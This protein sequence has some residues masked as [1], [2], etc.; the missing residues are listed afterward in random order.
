MTELIRYSVD[1]GIAQI[2]LDRPQK[3]N[4]LN[5]EMLAGLQQS[6]D[7][8]ERDATVRV[9]VL[10]GNG[11]RSFC[12]G[13]DI[14]EWSE[15]TALEMWKGWIRPGNQIMNRISQLAIPVIASLNGLALGGGLELALT[16]DIRIAADHALLGAPEVKLGIIPGW[17]GTQR[18][19][20]T[21]GSSRAK[22]MIFTGEQISADTALN[23]GLVN[24]VV[25][26]EN[27][28]ARTGEI[29]QSIARNAPVA[30]QAAKSLLDADGSVTD[31]MMLEGIAGALV[32][33]TDDARAGVDA[34][35]KRTVPEFEGH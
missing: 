23:W 7:L 6:L 20:H 4:A 3:L 29:A 25:A 32:T 9:L 33:Y 10:T 19:S 12:V 22:Q 24:E 5:G 8:V 35:K 2:T 26:S 14:L 34:F 21:I 11:E 15:L 16:A 31:G 30:V 27:L 28:A 13:A 1:Q 17:G 18:L